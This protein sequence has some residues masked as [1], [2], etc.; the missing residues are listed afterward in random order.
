[1]PLKFLN[2]PTFSGSCMLAIALTFTGFMP[3]PDLLMQCPMKVMLCQAV[4]IFSAFSFTPS[5]LHLPMNPF[6]CLLCSC[7]FHVSPHHQHCSPLQEDLE[8]L[9]GS[10]SE[11][12]QMTHLNQ[13]EILASYISQNTIKNY[14]NI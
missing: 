2:S 3:S 7:L 8:R 13:K 1:M 5:S 10:S 12:S 4:F 9:R 11:I 6:Q 14:C